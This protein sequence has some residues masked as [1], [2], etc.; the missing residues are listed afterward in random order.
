VQFTCGKCGTSRQALADLF[1]ESA[2]KIFLVGVNHC[3]VHTLRFGL[4]S[5]A[6]PWTHIGSVC[7]LSAGTRSERLVNPDAYQRGTVFVQCEGC[8]VWH[9][10]V[11]NMGLVQEYD[12]R[13]MPLSPQAM[14]MYGM[15]K[16]GNRTGSLKSDQDSVDTDSNMHGMGAA[17][18]QQGQARLSSDRAEETNYSAPGGRQLAYDDDTASSEYESTAGQEL[19]SDGGGSGGGD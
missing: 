16:E 6:F 7:L 3:F 2:R 8:D 14:A 9:Q 17:A 12:L 10:L 4:A 13:N 15:D 11:D 5:A 18:P 1:S 19:G